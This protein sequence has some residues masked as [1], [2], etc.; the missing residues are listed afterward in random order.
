MED[1]RR[2]SIISFRRA[3]RNKPPPEAPPTKASAKRRI[4][5]C[6][7]ETLSGLKY[8]AAWTLYV[9][10]G[11]WLFLLFEVRW[12]P[13]VEPRSQWR[14]YREVLPTAAQVT[15]QLQHLR[16]QLQQFCAWPGLAG[17]FTAGDDV[18]DMFGNFSSAGEHLAALERHCNAS[19]HITTL[20]RVDSHWSF[21]D[22][23]YYTMTHVTTIGYGHIVPSTRWGRMF[24][25]IYA[26]FGV[27]LT[28]ILMAKN[29]ELLSRKLLHLY[30]RLKRKYR[31]D[32]PADSKKT[33][34]ALTWAYMVFGFVV[35][36]FLPSVAFVYLEGWTYDTALYYTFITLSTIGFGEFVGGYSERTTSTPYG[37]L[38]KICI[39]LWIMLALGYWVLLLSFLQKALKKKIVPKR[40]K[41][42]FKAL[43]VAKQAEFLRQLMTKVREQGQ[44]SRGTSA[45]QEEGR[46]VMSLMAEVAGKLNDASRPGSLRQNGLK[47]NYE[48]TND[49]KL[50]GHEDEPGQSLQDLLSAEVVLRSPKAKFFTNLIS[51]NPTDF[52]KKLGSVDAPN[53][54]KRKQDE[55][56]EV[57]LPLK[58]VLNL[59]TLVANLECQTQGDNP[60]DD[61]SL[62]STIHSMVSLDAKF[63]KLKAHFKNL[64]DI[65]HNAGKPSPMHKDGYM[66]VSSSQAPG[67]NSTSRV[68]NRASI[69]DAF[70]DDNTKRE[71]VEVG[72][73]GGSEPKREDSDNDVT[74]GTEELCIREDDD[75][76]TSN[77]N[78]KA[79]SFE[80]E[81]ES[82]D[83]DDNELVCESSAEKTDAN[84]C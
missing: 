11:A 34:Y 58:D 28:C 72:H 49:N 66:P 53:Q 30:K 46:H 10:A 32:A 12:L 25:V 6:H 80:G 83:E 84:V 16:F 31:P 65:K 27:P 73:E 64:H 41:V 62:H 22:A 8:A 2:T 59:V 47:D 18:F 68:Q 24:A 67:S 57:T 52:S 26:L 75:D 48:S 60:N 74:L 82:S 77:D 70:L 76:D 7:G 81:Y 54:L 37:D 38:Y 61:L 21:V 56:D 14:V 19:L 45:P 23:V 39:V 29:S 69:L 4:G 63:P 55:S 20:E 15:D 43:Q 13:R 33:L 3:S 40:I 36:M 5:C 35:F 1:R 78:S 44:T 17:A 42:Q 71:Y 51:Q 79:L 9:L 50:N